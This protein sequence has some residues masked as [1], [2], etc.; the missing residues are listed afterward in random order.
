MSSPEFHPSIKEP[1]DYTYY[2]QLHIEDSPRK[3]K[4]IESIL[5]TSFRGR[6]LLDVGCDAGIITKAIAENIGVQEVHGVELSK[7]ATPYAEKSLQGFPSHIIHQVD[8]NDFKI[9]SLVDLTMFIDVLEHVSDPM[10]LLKKTAQ[11]SRYAIIRSPLEDAIAVQIHQQL[12]GEDIHKLMEERYG[13]IHHFSRKGIRSL[14]NQSNFEIIHE[15][16]TRI[17]KEASILNRS[18]NKFTESLFWRVANNFYP[19]FWGGFYVAFLKSRDAQ[20]VDPKSAQIVQEALAEEFGEQNIVSIAVFGSTTRNADKKHSDY[21]FTVILKNLPSDV[22]QKEQASPRIKRRLREKGVDELCAFNFYTPEEFHEADTNQSWLI[23]TMKTEYR[24]LY[25]KDN[26]LGAKLSA[27]KPTVEHVGTFAWRGVD[28]EDGLHLKSVIEKYNQIAKLIKDIDPQLSSYYRREGYRGILIEKLY[29]HGEYDTRSSLLSLAKRLNYRYG[30]NLNFSLL[31]TEDFLHETEGKEAIY[32]YNQVDK[33]LQIATILGKNGMPLDALF[34]TYS[35]LRNIYLYALHSNDHYIVEGEITQLFLREFSKKISPEL[36]DHIYENSFKAEQILGR[37]GYVSFNLD[38]KGK[39]IY[40]NPSTLAFNY[41]QLMKN[42]REIIERLRNNRSILDLRED[43][44]KSTISIVIATY[45]REEK[46][47][48]CLQGLNRL[49]IPDGKVELV[50]VD[51]GSEK[52]YAV[53][54]LQAL[55]R[56]PIRY[57]RKQHS[58]ICSTKNKGVEESRG[59]YIAFLDDDMVVSPLWLVQLMSGF[60]NDQIAGVGSTNLIYPDKNN[61]TQY[62]DYRELA[63]KPFRDEIEEVLNVLTGSACFRKDILKEVGGFSNA[64]SESGVM[65]GGDDVDLTW[66]IRNAGYLLR[67]IEEAIAFHNHRG[68]IKALIKQHIGYGEG[69]MFHCI[70][71]GRDPKELAIPNPTYAS[72]VKDTLHYL[73]LEVPKRMKEV[74]KNHLGLKRAIQYS[75]LD[76]IRKSSYNFGVLKARRFLRTLRK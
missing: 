16:I 38:Q 72:V 39:P 76:L 51:D 41:G 17:P 6:K 75:F 10:S 36:V 64:Q 66:K 67:H 37:S 70:D 30:E 26:F 47:K 1:M 62:I 2:S 4:E 50:V 43:Q 23:E 8:F 32:G 34:H 57:F 48:N 22:H 28:Y 27:I 54:Q 56:F 65:F 25:D 12:Y 5:P 63:R 9:N 42:M 35:A 7:I 29:R 52:S 68:D 31:Q 74:Y 13:H 73:L 3:I 20:I 15:N 18:L 49:I 40:E 19:E 58:G 60:K 55:S 33:H 14:I 21:D 71:T 45:N 61:L 24:V 69:T 44:N 11:I 46:L 59:N 53:E